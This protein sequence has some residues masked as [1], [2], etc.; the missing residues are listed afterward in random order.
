MVTRLLVTHLV[1][2]VVAIAVARVLFSLVAR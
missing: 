2:A 1:T